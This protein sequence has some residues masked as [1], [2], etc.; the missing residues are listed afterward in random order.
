MIHRCIYSSIKECKRKSQC[1]KKCKKGSVTKIPDC[2]HGR[3]ECINCQ[4]HMDC[5]DICNKYPDYKCKRNGYCKCIKSR[6]KLNIECKLP[7]QCKK[8]C[9]QGKEGTIPVCKKRTCV[10]KRCSEDEE[11]R[12]LCKGSP[13]TRCE[14]KTGKC[15]CLEKL[16]V[17]FAILFK[18]P[19]N[20]LLDNKNDNFE[21]TQNEIER[22]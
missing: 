19:I 9:W 20:W 5:K 4:E 10:C 11:C 21:I 22:S 2:V 7:S 18:L 15:R 1:K 6:P 8:K 13:R 12:H 16:L 14:R 17:C 3:C